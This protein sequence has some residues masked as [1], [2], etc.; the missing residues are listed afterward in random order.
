MASG[1]SV[2]QTTRAKAKRVIRPS[3]GWASLHLAELWE[4]RELLYF[5]T[6]RDIKVRYKQAVLGVVWAVLQPVLTVFVFTIVF[7]LIMKAKFQPTVVNGK[8]VPYFIYTYVG[9]LPWNLFAGALGRA[10]TSL[11]GNA[12]LLTKVYFPRLV[13]PSSAVVSGIVDFAIAFAVF[14]VLM[15]IYGITPSWHMVWLPLLLVIAMLTALA[16]GLWLS[17]LNVLYRDVQ[18]IIPFLVQLWMFLSAVFYN[19]PSFTHHA[20]L[21]FIY[22]LNPMVGVIVG[23]RWALIGGPAP[24]GMVALASAVMLA[25]LASGLVYFKRMERTFADVV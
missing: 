21:G 24:N 10:G 4:Y 3:R 18:Y 14:L 8:I 7:N 16:F 11:V 12:N 20:T 13:I 25:V 17:A 15:A 5:L 19:P 6:W 1:V 22:N 2:P 23:F 9:L